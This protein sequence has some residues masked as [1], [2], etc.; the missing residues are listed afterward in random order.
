MELTIHIIEGAS[1]EFLVGRLWMVDN[2][3]SLKQQ[4][5]GTF[6]V[7][8]RVDGQGRERHKE[9]QAIESSENITAMA[10]IESEEESELSQTQQTK[11]EEAPTPRVTK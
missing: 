8:Q 6:V 9:V 4:P 1:Y 7:M 10:T 2:Q 11:P 3:V 5:K